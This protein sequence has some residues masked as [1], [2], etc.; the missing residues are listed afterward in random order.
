[1]ETTKLLRFKK[2][3]LKVVGLDFRIVLKSMLNRPIALTS[4]LCKY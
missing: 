4:N 1:M 3:K 2:N